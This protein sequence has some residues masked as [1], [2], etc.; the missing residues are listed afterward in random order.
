MIIHVLKVV[1]CS[2]RVI[3]AKKRHHLRDFE[4]VHTCLAINYARL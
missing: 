4:N 2:C 3:R 1:L